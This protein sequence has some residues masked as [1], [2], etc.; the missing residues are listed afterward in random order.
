MYVFF[1]VLGFYMF[2]RSHHQGAY[3][4]IPLKHTAISGCTITRLKQFIAPNHV[5]AK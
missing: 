2:W 4:K 3:T 5:V 1:L